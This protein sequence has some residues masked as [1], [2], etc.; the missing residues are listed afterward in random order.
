M[1][2][3]DFADV[4]APTGYFDLQLSGHSH[5]GQVVMPGAGPLI[6]PRNGQKY[7]TGL[8][9]IAHENGAMLQFTGRGTGS[10]A[11]SL[12]GTPVRFNCPPEVA[13]LTLRSV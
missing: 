5:G 7:H 3:P 11:L 10:S 13:C 2:E 6:L 8:Y 12:T 9:S 4:S 1:H